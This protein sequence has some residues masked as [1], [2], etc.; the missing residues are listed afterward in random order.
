MNCVT[1]TGRLCKNPEIKLV[2]DK[3]VAKFSIAVNDKKTMQ[4]DYI[5]VTAWDLL[6]ESIKKYLQKGSKINVVGKIKQNQYKDSENK[7]INRIYVQAEY[8]D[9]LANTK[10][11]T[12]EEDLFK[13]I[14]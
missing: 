6:A 14:Y 8:I 2:N 9:Y 3:K 12:K 5:E 10:E 4:V 1:L 11:E 13:K 7:T